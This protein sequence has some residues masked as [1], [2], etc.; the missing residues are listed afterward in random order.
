M[1]AALGEYLK[2][3]TSKNNILYSSLVLRRY[4]TKE[5]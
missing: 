5:N 4:S 3:L 2:E 1:K